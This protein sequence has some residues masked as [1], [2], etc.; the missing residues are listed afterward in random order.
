MRISSPPR[1]NGSSSSSPIMTSGDVNTV[2]IGV[3]SGGDS[4]RGIMGSEHADSRTNNA[5]KLVNIFW[6]ISK[7]I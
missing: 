3:G 1:S 7:P 6:L 5:M 2:W 4:T